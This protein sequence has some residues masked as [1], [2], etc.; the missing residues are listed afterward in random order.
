MGCLG[1]F[2]TGFAI[3]KSEGQNAKCEL[4]ARY[5]KNTLVYYKGDVAAD[6]YFDLIVELY[7]DTLVEMEILSRFDKDELFSS[8]VCRECSEWGRAMVGNTRYLKRKSVFAN[9]ILPI[10]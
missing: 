7:S 1:G 10:H 4:M 5:F 6:D 2:G 3:R 9:A 8:D